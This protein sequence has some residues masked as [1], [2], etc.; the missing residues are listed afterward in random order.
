VQLTRGEVD[1]T[2][3]DTRTKGPRIAGI[4]TY[5]PAGTEHAATNAG[6]TPF[7][8]ISIAMKPSRSPAAPA[9]PTEAPPGITRT[10]LADNAEVRVVRVVFTPGS[11]EPVHTHPNDLVT[12]QL[13]A[14]RLQILAG[15][16]RTDRRR[17]VGFVQFVPRNQA[18]AYSWR[19]DRTIELLSVSVK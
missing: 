18:H 19:G 11:R 1:L 4:V 17:P 16:R 14:G 9:P 5:V 15:G 7:D 3:G 2:V 12:I 8:M 10:T 6:S 13:N